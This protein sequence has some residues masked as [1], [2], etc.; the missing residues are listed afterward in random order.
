MY[1]NAAQISP[2]AAVTV[3]IV[4]ARVTHEPATAPVQDGRAG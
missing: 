3:R 2:R 4:A 1:Y